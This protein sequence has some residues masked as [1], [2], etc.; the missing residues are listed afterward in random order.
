M[1]VTDADRA[2]FRPVLTIELDFPKRS[3]TVRPQHRAAIA[4]PEDVGPA[5][6]REIIRTDAGPGPRRYW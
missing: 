1:I 3:A 2:P 4:G 6:D 5:V